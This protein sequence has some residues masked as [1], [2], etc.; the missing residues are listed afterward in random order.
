MQWKDNKQENT[1]TFEELDI[2]DVFTDVNDIIHIKINCEEGF[3]I[4]NNTMFCFSKD[5]QVERRNATLVLD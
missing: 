3:D 5:D 4:Y 2:G 1:T